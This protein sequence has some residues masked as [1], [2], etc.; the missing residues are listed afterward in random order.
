[1]K[2]LCIIF[3]VL[4]LLIVGIMV[5][6][7]FAEMPIPIHVEWSY[8]VP[9]FQTATQEAGFRFYVSG[10]E[11]LQLGDPMARSADVTAPLALG[12]NEI[13]MTAFVGSLESAPSAPF[14]VKRGL[15]SPSINSAE[16]IISK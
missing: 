8:D 5:K 11:F 12:D 15:G 13:T 1:M 2:K 7:A 6:L 16:L 9:E 4:W 14:V 10:V 3:A